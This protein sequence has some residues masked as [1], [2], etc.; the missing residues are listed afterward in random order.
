[1]TQQER[2]VFNK[3][4][5]EYGIKSQ[6]MMCI[7]ECAELIDALIKYRN[8]RCSADDVVS[9]IADVRIMVKQMAMIFGEDKV[10]DQVHYKLG[11]LISRMCFPCSESEANTAT[12]R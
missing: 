8:G 2:E 9:E 4:L 11:R 5:K 7:E 12:K 6:K 10:K 1:M 3:A